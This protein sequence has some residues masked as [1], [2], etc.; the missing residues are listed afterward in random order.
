[1][2]SVPKVKR[3]AL[4]TELGIKLS[5][6]V[7]KQDYNLLIADNITIINMIQVMKNL[8]TIDNIRET[9]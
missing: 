9:V 7:L 2:P 1:V 8:K 6:L 5:N 3:F 4:L